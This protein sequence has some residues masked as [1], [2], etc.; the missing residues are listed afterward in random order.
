MDRLKN[1]KFVRSS[2]YLHG[3]AR[4]RGEPVHIRQSEIYRAL[5]L[6]G[7]TVS[8]P[9]TINAATAMTDPDAERQSDDP[10]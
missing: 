9:R 3:T 1:T 6:N 10:Y 4:I 5:A 2:F 8:P 7:A